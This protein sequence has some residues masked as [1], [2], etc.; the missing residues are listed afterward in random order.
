MHLVQDH[1]PGARATRVPC[2]GCGPKIGP[3]LSDCVIDL[4]GPAFQAYYCPS[5]RPVDG[6]GAA[7][8]AEKCS[9]RD[10]TR[11]NLTGRRS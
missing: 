7:V 4:D 1:G 5:H 3:Y 10:C 11:C 8:P 2:I 9:I 6:H